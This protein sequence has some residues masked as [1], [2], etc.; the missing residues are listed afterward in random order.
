MLTIYIDAD[1][2]PVKEEIYKVAGRYNLKV[3]VVS[4]K[5]MRIP[6]HPNITAT[7]VGGRLDE[8]DDW[9]VEHIQEHDILITGDIPLADR[10]LKKGA[11]VLGSKGVEFTHDMI[12]EAMATREIMNFLRDSG[13]PNQHHTPFEKKDR[14]L[15]LSKLDQI[16]QSLKRKY[17]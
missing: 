17:S 15:F 9:I 14:S 13:G 11:A 5:S 1:A 10:A 7:V 2:C 16:I 8:A 3:I 6:H 12:G 4:N